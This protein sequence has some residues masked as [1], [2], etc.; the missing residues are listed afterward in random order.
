[1]LVRLPG[2]KGAQESVDRPCHR[3]DE[4]ASWYTRARRK[5]PCCVLV[6][7]AARVPNPRTDPITGGR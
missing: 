3:E 6:T 1:M 7:K 4:G 5:S 2:G